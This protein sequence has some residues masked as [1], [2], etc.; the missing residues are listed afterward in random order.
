M[1]SS[2]PHSPWRGSRADPRQGSHNPDLPTRQGFALDRSTRAAADYEVFPMKILALDNSLT[3]SG[4]CLNG[5]ADEFKPAE[6]GFARIAEIS[7]NVIAHAVDVDVV[8]I[9][10]YSYGSKGR[11]ITGLAEL[12]GV[13]RYRLENLGIPYTVAAPTSLKRYATGKGN[14][15][16]EV[17]LAEAIRRLGYQGASLDEADALWL[18]EMAADH[19]LGTRNVPASHAVALDKIEWPDVG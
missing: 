15:K 6:K 14:S 10:G 19:Y 18:F 1:D 16:K 7:D 11:A 9:E 5:D 2:S 12:G 4:L 17:V 3:C 8:I 13:I